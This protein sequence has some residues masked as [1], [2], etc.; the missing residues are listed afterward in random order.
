MTHN[1][2]D[3]VKTIPANI[4]KNRLLQK[5]FRNK[6]FQ[7]VSSMIAVSTFIVATSILITVNNNPSKT[8]SASFPI[9]ADTTSIIATMDSLL[10]S[11][12]TKTSGESVELALNL[13]NTGS[14]DV[15]SEIVIDVYNTKNTVKWETATFKKTAIKSLDG[16]SF[17]L[18]NLSKLEKTKYILKGTITNNDTKNIAA[19]TRVKYTVNDSA[20]EITSNRIFVS[21]DNSIKIEQNASLKINKLEYKSDEKM[22]FT[23]AKPTNVQEEWLGQLVVN[24]KNTGNIVANIECKILAKESKCQGEIPKLYA[25]QYFIVFMIN[26]MQKS[27]LINFAINTDTLK[28]KVDNTIE[29]FNKFRVYPTPTKIE[30]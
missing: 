14:I 21:L 25:G 8:V 12:V 15:L 19:M 16:H 11:G 29:I 22:L 1:Y 27:N 26:D 2:F 9:S 24:N 6:K 13:Q 23:V 5:L 18:P 10:P 3:R 17:S 30:K 28:D 4:Q 7:I 20:K